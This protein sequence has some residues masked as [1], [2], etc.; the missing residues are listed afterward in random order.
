LV[1]ETDN[2]SID[3]AKE[4]MYE[5]DPRT[6]KRIEK[7]AAGDVVAATP[8]SWLWSFGN[9]CFTRFEHLLHPW[10]K[11]DIKRSNN[12]A[13]TRSSVSPFPYFVQG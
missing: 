4:K 13:V 1:W 10:L 11:C 6:L 3:Q 5:V 9:E 8:C 7:K 12:T 2:R